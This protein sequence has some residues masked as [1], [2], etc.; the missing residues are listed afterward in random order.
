VS[1]GTDAGHFCRGGISTAVF[2]PGSI[3]RAHRPDEF[4]EERELAACLAFLDNLALH[5]TR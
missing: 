3:K 4:I 2:G 1:F 5:L